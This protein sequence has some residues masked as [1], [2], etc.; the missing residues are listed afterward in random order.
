MDE[1]IKEY[2]EINKQISEL[3]QKKE[4]LKAKI[5]QELEGRKFYE[6]SLG[7]SVSVT[8]QTRESIIPVQFESLLAHAQKLGIAGN[9]EDY[10]K[11]TTFTTMRVNTKEQREKYGSKQN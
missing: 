3:E 10:Y 8:E 11:K 7:N 9:K 2:M 6:D 1:H 5:T 4:V